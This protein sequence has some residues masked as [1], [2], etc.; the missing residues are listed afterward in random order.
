MQFSMHQMHLAKIGCVWVYRHARAM[1]Y[2]Q[3]RMRITRNPQPRQQPDM[4]LRWLGH[5]MFGAARHGDYGRG[6]FIP[7]VQVFLMGRLSFLS[8]FL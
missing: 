8:Y 6:H 5:G 2:R 4:I 1:P 3:P 7:P